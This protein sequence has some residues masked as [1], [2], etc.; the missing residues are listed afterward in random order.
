MSTISGYYIAIVDGLLSV[1]ECCYFIA[2]LN[3]IEQLKRVES[4][5]SEYERNI[6]VSPEWAE[7]LYARVRPHLPSKYHQDT[8]CNTTFRFSKYSEGQQFKTHRDGVNQDAKGYRTRFTVIFFLND[9]FMQG[10]T[11]FFDDEGNLKLTAIPAPGRG[12]IFDREI[13]HR[14]N[15]VYGGYKYL[16]RTDVMVSDGI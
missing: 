3:K 5:I 7:R 15:V 11:E 2:H 1:E 6:M 13:Q 10:E 9:T 4:D 16:L 12:A 8:H 14:G